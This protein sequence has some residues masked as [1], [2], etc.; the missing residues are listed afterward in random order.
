[1]RFKCALLLLSSL[2]S[3]AA[4]ADPESSA[5][6]LCEMEW[7][8]TDKS[9]STKLSVQQIVLD[10]V[11]AFKANGHSLSEYSIDEQD[12]IKVSVEGGES[13]RKMVGKMTTPYPEAREFFRERMMP[14]CIKNV[15]KSLNKTS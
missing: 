7:R 5:K 2:T 14:L 15:L 3:F 6:D 9:S 4:W 10:E 11:K 13:F 8:I 1:M 12:F